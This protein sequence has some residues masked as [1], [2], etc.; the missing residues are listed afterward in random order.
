MCKDFA[1]G[2]DNYVHTLT[3]RQLS[4]VLLTIPHD[5]VY[6]LELEPFLPRRT[7]GFSLPDAHVW[8]IV[9]DA[10]VACPAN[11]VRGLLS[12]W[13]VDYNRAPE[14]AYESTQ[15]AV[16]YQCYHGAIHR[17]LREMQQRFA[18]EGLLLIDV[19][20]FAV[21]PA[22]APRDGYDLILGTGNRTTIPYG[23]PDQ[24]LATFLAARGYTVFLPNTETH[25]KLYDKLNGGFTVR[26]VA[27]ELG[28]NSIQIE[29]ARRFRTRD[30]AVVGTRLSADLAEF[31]SKHYAS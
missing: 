29:I 14:N 8:P 5:G 10:I 26:T 22:Y 21:Q 11:V 7:Q 2:I 9:R 30:A 3:A 28:I 15:L 6:G 23:A 12:R 27:R 1:V 20:G 16:P 24:A 31:L 25:T 19:H 17:Q 18:R 13:F 4:P